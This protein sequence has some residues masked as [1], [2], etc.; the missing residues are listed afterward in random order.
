[1]KITEKAVTTRFTIVLLLTLA[2][3]MCFVH[4]VLAREKTL[5]AQQ[6]LARMVTT[7]KSLNSYSSQVQLEVRIK[8]QPPIPKMQGELQWKK[9]Y[10]AAIR[11]RQS[12]ESGR[13]VFDGKHLWAVSS[14]HKGSYVRQ[15]TSTTLGT[16]RVLTRAGLVGNGIGVLLTHPESVHLVATPKSLSLGTKT[17]LKGAPVVTVI[18]QTGQGQERLTLTFSIGQKDFLLHKITTEQLTN[19]QVLTMHE[20]YSQIKM[21]LRLPADVFKFIPPHGA[22]QIEKFP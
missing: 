6:Y 4:P 2:W 3:Q 8:G 14:L 19:G 5:T 16:M 9:P 20:T 12:G 18:S 13:A 21:N 17:T 7:Y 1:M 10:F 22:K 11:Y 15:P